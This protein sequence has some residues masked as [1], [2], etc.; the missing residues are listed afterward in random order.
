[1]AGFKGSDEARRN[2]LASMTDSRTHDT[3]ALRTDGPAINPFQGRT[4]LREACMIRLER[5]AADPSPPRPELGAEAL[6][7]LAASLRQRGQLQPIRVRW[8]E[9]EGRYIVV[10]G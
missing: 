3:G 2:R 5:I 9:E 10:L 8:D 7:R 1:M 6:D 4:Q